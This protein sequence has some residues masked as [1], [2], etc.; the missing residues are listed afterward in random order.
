MSS[1]YRTTTN[2]DQWTAS[3]SVR[4]AIVRGLLG[5]CVAK[6]PATVTGAAILWL[7]ALMIRRNGDRSGTDVLMAARLIIQI[8]GQ[9]VSISW[10]LFHTPYRIIH[11]PSEYVFEFENGPLSILLQLPARAGALRQ[12]IL[13]IVAI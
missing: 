6:G 13:R 2:A 11:V 10:N 4:S 1:G 7:A 3:P 12:D 9:N 8:C 5:C